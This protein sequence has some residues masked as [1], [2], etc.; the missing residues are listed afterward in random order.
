MAQTGRLT[1]HTGF[2][3]FAIPV[4]LVASFWGVER[5][6]QK[7]LNPSVLCRS[8]KSRSGGSGDR[9]EPYRWFS[10]TGLYSKGSRNVLF[11]QV[12][13]GGRGYQ[14]Q[15]TTHFQE[16]NCLLALPPKAAGPTNHDLP[17]DVALVPP[18]FKKHLANKHDGIPLRYSCLRV[19]A[20]R[21]ATKL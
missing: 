8:R 12:F 6:N 10:R 5:P 4:G 15:Q 2:S 1:H 18:A 7:Q 17:Q 21:M 3:G 19:A 14:G 13:F 11:G 20:L 9:F 16:N